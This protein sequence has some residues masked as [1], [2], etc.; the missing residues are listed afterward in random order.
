M[1]SDAA[2][3]E[4]LVSVTAS[5]HV[6]SVYHPASPRRT[7]SSQVTGVYDRPCPNGNSGVGSTELAEPC[8]AS[9]A[10]RYVEGWLDPTPG[11]PTGSRPA[12]LTRPLSTPATAPAPSSP[13]KKPHTVA[14][15]RS[16]WRPSSYGRPASSTRTTG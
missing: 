2:R 16:I 9:G 7:T 5:S 13:G 11:K 8:W 12:G 10:A 3:S 4:S 15:S 6:P 14:A 1:T